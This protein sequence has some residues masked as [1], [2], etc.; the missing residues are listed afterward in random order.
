MDKKLHTKLIGPQ[1]FLRNRKNPD[2][3]Q[4]EG[5]IKNDNQPFS[6]I[7]QISKL[8][9]ETDRND[10]NV[11][12]SDT[13]KETEMK[14]TEMKVTET[15]SPEDNSIPTYPNLKKDE[16]IETILRNVAINHPKLNT[17]WTKLVTEKTEKV[18]KEEVPRKKIQF[19]NGFL[20][21]IGLI[22]DLA[23]CAFVSTMVALVLFRL[24]Y[25]MFQ[26]LDC[27]F[28]QIPNYASGKVD[29]SLFFRIAKIRFL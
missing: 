1:Q 16:K 2:D 24:I 21:S 14:A 22:I 17:S 26:L 10:L 6:E 29:W 9:D 3:W 25:Q 5:T 28:T 4:T 18:D 20:V 23:I 7:D 13:R 15:K 12:I 19:R 27:S 11:N 8:H